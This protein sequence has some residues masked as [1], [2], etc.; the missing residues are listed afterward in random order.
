MTMIVAGASRSISARTASGTHVPDTRSSGADTAPATAP[1]ASASGKLCP[2]AR[3]TSG[4]VPGF[5]FFDTDA[6]IT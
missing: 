5:E 4:R 6:D 1:P 2:V 3:N